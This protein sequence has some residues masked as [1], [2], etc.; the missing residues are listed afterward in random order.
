MTKIRLLPLTFWAIMTVL[1]T[2]VS[3]LSAS[4]IVTANAYLSQDK[5]RPGDIINIALE[6]QIK[7]GFHINANKPA[8]EF[9]IPTDVSFNQNDNFSVTEIMYPE[10]E[11]ISFAFSDEPLLV[12]EK[13]LYFVGKLV[14]SENVSTM[15][16][17]LE[18]V[19]NYQACN[20]HTC[21]APDQATF[22]AEI[23]VVPPGTE[24][25]KINEEIFAV[26]FENL[27]IE[28]KDSDSLDE[29]MLT[30][31]EARAKEIIEK[32]L[33]YA[34]AAFF[35]LGLALNLTPCVYPV[36]PITIS[37]FGGRSAQGK[38]SAWLNATMYVLGIA[39]VFSVLGLVSG[40]AG[41]Q[42]GF[43]FQNPWFVLVIALIM[44]SMA[45]SMFG[46]FEIVVPSWLMTKLGGTREGA[47]G[48]LMMGLTVGVVIAPCA[49][50]IIIGLVGLVAKM[51][52]ALQGTLL[53]FVMGL[54]LGLPYLFLASF[55]SFLDRLPQSG[56]WMLWVR[57]LF[58]VLLVGVA[59]YFLMPQ[60]Q[61][62]PNQLG[63]F[64]GLLIIFGGLLLGF[65]DH[66][67]GYTKGF[68]IGRAIFGV[69]AIVFG[70]T[71]FSN[72]LQS[73]T[74]GIMWHD[75]A[76]ESLEEYAVE[77]KPIFLDFYADWCAP[78]KQM[79]RT[80][81]QDD[82]VVE[83]STKFTMVKIDCTAPDLATNE[84]MK[85]YNVTGMP[86]YI[87]LSSEGLEINS[88]REIGYVEAEKFVQSMNKA[89]R[90]K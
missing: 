13:T 85:K 80:T 7:Q 26:A 55:S 58:G 3:V 42:W 44:L 64:F 27:G 77:G 78:C 8:E 73:K 62:A 84:L 82:Q 50:G 66:A 70:I 88:L 81:F 24:I 41:K 34:I 23:E 59:I 83:L 87:F 33:F 4:E 20:D 1:F 31:D 63:F 30:K 29:S 6:L 38:G 22:I 72:A 90:E 61:R 15:K 60:A 32:G 46:A 51:G 69:V 36:L 18:G 19:V 86:T 65:L 48:G 28:E 89:L 47:M 56:T 2:G 75:Y 5:V 12:Y 53:F 14:I 35:V 71:V 40:L 21:M 67:P 11:F 79:D 68:K 43:L 74:T 57:K 54:G 17:T 45:A 76:G 25:I 16:E 49:A 37:Y 52:I 10:G 39:I 9:Y